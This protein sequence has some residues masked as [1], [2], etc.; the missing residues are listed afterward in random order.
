M[1]ITKA[2]Q[3]ELLSLHDKYGWGGTGGKYAGDMVIRILA[4][5]PDLI[6][7]LDYGCGEG[8][9]QE[10]VE[11]RGITNRKWTMYDPGVAGLEVKPEG[12]FDLVIT[13]DVLE[14]VEPEKQ[15]E[16]ITELCNYANKAM[17]NEIACYE[18]DVKF[19]SGPYKGKDLHINLKIPCFWRQE[20]EEIAFPLGFER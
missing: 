17:F 13:T 10:Y 12:K 20:I 14:H 1:T 2:Y 19:P 18:T 3:K 15:D 7:I 11:Y 8:S 9:L 4:H 5:F 16:V 6:T